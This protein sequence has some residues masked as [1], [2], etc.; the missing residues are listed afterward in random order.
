MGTESCARHYP[1]QS[2][3][4]KI[5]SLAALYIPTS[6][7]D[8]SLGLLPDLIIS[9]LQI[10]LTFNYNEITLQLTRTLHGARNKNNVELLTQQYSED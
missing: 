6:F 9:S 7:A 3:T 2:S 5:T 1:F 8:Q 4:S 10:V